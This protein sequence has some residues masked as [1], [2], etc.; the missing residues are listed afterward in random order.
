MTREL[1]LTLLALQVDW[2][3]ARNRLMQ[4]C[5]ISDMPCCN[6]EF[7]PPN[8]DAW[9]SRK[10]ARNSDSTVSRLISFNHPPETFVYHRIETVF[11]KRVSPGA[12]VQS[13]D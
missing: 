4:E 1:W 11:E 6:V 3:F 10:H 2:A 12:I 8:C 5:S 9:K 7:A 13:K